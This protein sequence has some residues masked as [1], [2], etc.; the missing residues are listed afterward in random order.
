[1]KTLFASLL[2]ALLTGMALVA[3]AA[4]LG[5]STDVTAPLP[6]SHDK[7]KKEDKKDG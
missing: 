3:H 4:P 6:D 7:D 5:T 2:A 1:M